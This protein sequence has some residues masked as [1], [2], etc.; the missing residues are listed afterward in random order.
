MTLLVTVFGHSQKSANQVWDGLMNIREW[1]TGDATNLVDG[2]QNTQL[3]ALGVTKVV[4][5]VIHGL[6][7]VQHGTTQILVS[8]RTSRKEK[9]EKTPERLVALPYPS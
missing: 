4:L 2:V 9:G 6:G 8:C 3:R 7:G 1:E 5:P